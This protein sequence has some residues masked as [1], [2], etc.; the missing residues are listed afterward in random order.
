MTDSRVSAGERG[1]KQCCVQ[2]TVN[3]QLSA[4]CGA[5]PNPTAVNNAVSFSCTR[6]GGV[7]PYAYSWVFGDGGTSALQNPSHVYVTAGNYNACVT[8]TDALQEAK[9]CCVAVTVN[10]L[11]TAQCGVNANPAKVGR[12]AGFTC[13]PSGGV[14]PYAYSW[15]F[16]DGGTS[17][18]QNPGHTYA[19][20]AVYNVCVTV[21]DS[22]QNT[23]QCCIAVTAFR[24]G[25]ATGEGELDMGD[26]TKVERIIL[27]IDPP[28]LGADANE[29][30][31]ID[32]RDVTKI[33]R[34]IMQLDP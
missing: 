16:G 9:Q 5:V 29:D 31:V 10:P 20:S 26:V 7:G 14:G 8:V 13:T 21:T 28:T 33:E 23:R 22:L 24:V 3:P 11:L 19:G 25:D 34:I 18:S 32:M 17:A 6:S 15:A 30:G 12:I 27:G 4:T 2:V 1:T